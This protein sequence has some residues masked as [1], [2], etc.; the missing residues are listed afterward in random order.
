MQSQKILLVIPPALQYNNPFPSTAYIKGYLQKKGY[1]V[2]QYDLNIELF[3]AL[4]SKEKLQQFFDEAEEK[5]AK[6]SR[7][8]RLILRNRIRYEKT[9]NSTI[10]FL[11][12]NH[13]TLSHRIASREFL[14]EANHFKNV[15]DLDWSFGTLGTNDLAK[16]I[17]TLYLEDIADFITECI[18]PHFSFSRYAEKI[19][20]SA[21]C[22]DEMYKEL[23]AKD[24]SVVQTMCDLLTG[25]ITTEQPTIVGFTIPFPGNVLSAL[26]CARTIKKDFP[27][28]KTIFGGGYCNTELRNISDPRFF[29]YADFMTLDDGETPFYNI[30]QYID[31]KV[32]ESELMRTFC[33]EKGQVAFKNNT[34]KADGIFRNVAHPDFSDFD[35]SKYVCLFDVTNPMHRLWSDGKWNK[36]ML[37]HGCYWHKCTFCDI[38]LDYIG[39]FEPLSAQVICD[40]VE[41]TIAQT[42]ESGFHFVDE[43]APPTLLRD[44]AQEIIKRELTITWWANIRFEKNFTRDLCMLLAQAGCI[45]VTGGLEVASDRIL[46]LIDKGVDLEQVANVTNYFTS[47]GIMVH[48]YL[49]YG[50]PTQTDQETID[51]LEVVRQFFELGLLQ[52]AFWH[53]FTAT[54]H[55]PVGCNPKHFS[56]KIKNRD[57]SPFANNDLIHTD[58]T[59]AIHDK[60]DDGL[61]VALYNYMQGAGFDMPL[62]EWFNFK[63]R[64]TTLPPFYIENM[65]EK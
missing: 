34:A 20:Q 65:L 43:A 46:Q 9:I 12:G 13:Q 45:A 47:A 3:C 42:G 57:L 41:K 1:T 44:F 14:P 16:Y 56:I 31:G 55:S 25:K 28:I 35:F 37:A 60:Y 23:H 2:C 24:T 49:M 18:D 61:K 52:S 48:A 33:L 4:F 19:A 58:P 40:H 29:E 22:F 50:F 62:S 39:R 6:Y 63:V 30:L 8:S 17:A 26:K 53:R 15:Q 11:Q 32:N 5:G 38:N 51:S 54:R 10:A 64:N 36:L 21:P 7:H 59:G 27:K